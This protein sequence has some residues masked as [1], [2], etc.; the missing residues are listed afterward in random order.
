MA[1]KEFWITNV[2]DLNVSLRD[3]ALSVPAR[4]S[5]NLLD[6]KHFN[7]TLEQLEK[8]AESGSLFKKGKLIKVRKVAPDEEVKPGIHTTKTPL[9]MRLK[10]KAIIIEEPEYEELQISDEQ[11]A[12]EWSI[13]SEVEKEV[14]EKKGGK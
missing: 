5:M 14:E 10:Y 3:L 4:R 11:F 12:D 2:S 13:I 9:F 1:I 7:Y 6:S 8:S